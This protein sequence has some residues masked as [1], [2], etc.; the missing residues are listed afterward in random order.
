MVS[1]RLLQAPACLSAD[2]DTFALM[3]QGF[4]MNSG[5]LPQETTE[6]KSRDGQLYRSLARSYAEQL[7]R[8]ELRKKRITSVAF[9]ICTVFFLGLI[10]VSYLSR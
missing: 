7:Q 10:V 2:E 8:Q 1:A 9:V 3:Q 6:D 4:A 5:N